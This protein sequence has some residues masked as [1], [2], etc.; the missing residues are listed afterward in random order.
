MDC[1]P[2]KRRRPIT[3]RRSVI[4]QRKECSAHHRSYCEPCKSC[5]CYLS[6]FKIHFIILLLFV[7]LLSGLFLSGYSS[8]ILYACIFAPCVLHV[9]PISNRLNL[10]TR[11]LFG[12]RVDT[13][14]FSLFSFLQSPG[15]S[16]SLSSSPPCSRT[17]SA[18]FLPFV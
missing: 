15:T 13:L 17:P 18:N 10:I 12:V 2:S 3:Y 1:S 9:L 4:S 8:N 14:T 11:I 16:P 6:R 7:D 5:V